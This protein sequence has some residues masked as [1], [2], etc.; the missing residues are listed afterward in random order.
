MIILN[1]TKKK[2]KVKL[3]KSALMRGK[4]SG[5]RPAG[6]TKDERKYN[7]SITEIPAGIQPN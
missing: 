4:A 6:A 2:N 1:K 3:V 5:G 7:Y